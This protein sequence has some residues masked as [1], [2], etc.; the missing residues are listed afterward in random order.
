MITATLMRALMITAD[1]AV[2]VAAAA[3]DTDTAGHVDIVL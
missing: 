2:D 1:V 3:A